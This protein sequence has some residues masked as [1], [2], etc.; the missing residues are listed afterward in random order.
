MILQNAVLSVITSVVVANSPMV[1]GINAMVPRSEFI[2]QL[3]DSRFLKKTQDTV[4]LN[5]PYVNQMEDLPEDQKVVYTTTACGPAALTM[6]LNYL[7]YD[8]ELIDVIEKL[9]AN[10]YVRGRYFMKLNDGPLTFGEQ[11]VSFKNDPAEIFK[12][13]N[14]GYPVVLNVQNYDGFTGHALVAVGMKGFDGENA[15]SLIVHD[16]FVCAYR[17]FEYVNDNILR[18]PEGYLLAIGT[19]DPFYVK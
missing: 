8:L 5:V 11:A 16:P 7:G 15:Q 19:L 18:Q 10:V 6:G 4:V 12:V 3:G 13:L 17:E 9:P 2:T 14:D 1:E